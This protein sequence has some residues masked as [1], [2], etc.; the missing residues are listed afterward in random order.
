M[1]LEDFANIKGFK[2]N[3]TFSYSGN[4]GPSGLSQSMNFVTKNPSLIA[5][6]LLFIPLIVLCI[7]GFVSRDNKLGFTA[8]ALMIAI[9]LFGYAYAYSLGDRA[10]YALLISLIIILFG[11]LIYFAIQIKMRVSNNMYIQFYNPTTFKKNNGIPLSYYGKVRDNATL[12]ELM[13]GSAYAFALKE[14]LPVD[15]GTEGT[16]SFWLK[17][18]PINFNKLNTKWRTIWYRGDNSGGS[19]Q[20]IYKMKTP[21]VY[22]APNTN[23]MII[24]VACENGPDEGN[25]ITVD[26]IPLNEWFCTTITLDGRSLDCY[27]NGMLEYS[28]SLTGD[29]LMM[30]SNVIKG[31]DGFSGLMAFFRYNSAAML[32][33]QI[34]ELYERER[35]TLEDSTF[36][37][38][39]C[40]TES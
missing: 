3:N 28:I 26:N 5:G 16:Y 25:A 11:F 37:L 36:S 24:S 6:I 15:M 17:V 19:G 29:P 35:A 8:L 10:Q 30:N 7:K 20:S 18:C 27:I 2:T 40:P 38:E 4:Y 23:K 33:G 32:P 21:G 9:G 34:I 1:G 39:T 14:D 22:L 13:K 12:L 31:K